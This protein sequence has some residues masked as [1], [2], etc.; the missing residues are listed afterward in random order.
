[1]PYS[2]M[3]ASYLLCHMHGRLL[4]R[5]GLYRAGLVGLLL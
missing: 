2:H 1:M 5:H 3:H 4:A